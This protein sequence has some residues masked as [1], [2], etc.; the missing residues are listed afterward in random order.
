M[1]GS[2]AS[3][4]L[5]KTIDHTYKISKNKKS[6]VS[7]DAEDVGRGKLVISSKTEN[8]HAT[9]PNKFTSSYMGFPSGSEVKASACNVGDLGS[10]PGS[11]S[12]AI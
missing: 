3:E 12:L 11:G 10:I 8:V 1:I 6:A 2:T 4:N 9:W 5:G 7:S